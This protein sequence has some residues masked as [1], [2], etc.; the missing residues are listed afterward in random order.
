[1]SASLPASAEQ[2]PLLR[3]VSVSATGRTQAEPDMAHLTTGV[4]AEGKTAAEA[5]TKNS[6]AMRKVVDGLKALGIEGKDIQ[7][8]SFRVEPRHQH[9]KD[10][11][12]PTVVGYQVENEVRLVVR[13][14]KKLGSVLD[15]VVSLGAN[16]VG[17]ISFEVARQEELKDEARKTAMANALRRARLYAEAAGAGIGPVV[18]IQEEASSSWQPRP[19][20]YG[21]T[22]MAAEAAPMEPGTQALEVKVNVVWELR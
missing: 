1:M 11:R 14:L 19:I 13:D 20:A 6:Q 9:F 7:T 16:Q 17:G 2:K 12:P 4:L 15:E 21:R 10:G 22:A 3:T 5:L 8:N 18:S